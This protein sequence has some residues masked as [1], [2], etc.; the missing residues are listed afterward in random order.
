[1]PARGFALKIAI[2]A[3]VAQF[4]SMNERKDGSLD[5]ISWSTS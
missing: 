2:K 4:K 3:F 1:M 5:G